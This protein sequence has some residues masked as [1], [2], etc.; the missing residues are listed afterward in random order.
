MKKLSLVLIALLAFS[1]CSNNHYSSVSDGDE[2][3]YK[4]NSGKSYTKSDLYESMKSNDITDS[5]KIT[6]ISKL[7]N[8]EGVDMDSITSTVEE[9]V[10]AMV[11]GGYEQ[12]I[13]SYYGSVDNYKRS[14]IGNQALNELAKNYVEADFDSYVESYN[15]YKAEIVYFDDKD[16][17]QAVIDAVNSQENTF[18]YAC[19][20]N[21]YSEEV[22]ETLYT[23][24]DSDLPV[25]VKEYVLDEAEIGVS[26]IIEVATVTTDSD[27]NSNTTYR[28]YLV[29]LISKNVE[30]FRDEFVTKVVSDVDKDSI[31]NSLLEK[32]NFETHDQRVYELLKDTYEATK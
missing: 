10:N 15:P 2:V 23:D 28:Y 29:N 1:G 20:E 17:A 14:Y 22:S 12:F 3:I 31:I 27:G 4:D 21:G 16:S 32:Y 11:E 7:A 30:D 9:S 25:D 26:D 24:N 8:Y 6:L 18:E 13:I 19:S 5:L